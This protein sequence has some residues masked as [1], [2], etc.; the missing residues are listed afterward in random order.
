MN[1][2]EII[3]KVVA[4]LAAKARDALERSGTQEHE[5]IQRDLLIVSLTLS[6]IAN[7]IK[8]GAWK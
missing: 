8:N 1:E 5:R 4:L 2:E 6:T 7:D 3:T